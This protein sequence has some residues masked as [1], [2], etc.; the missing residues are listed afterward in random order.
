MKT[1]LIDEP[2]G[3]NVLT[4][5]IFIKEGGLGGQSLHLLTFINT[6]EKKK[7]HR[8]KKSNKKRKCSDRVNIHQ[9]KEEEGGWVA[10]SACTM[11]IQCSG[12]KKRS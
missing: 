5:S 4:A 9:F 2:R 3:E 10:P 7:M 6:V 12:L 1:Q 8:G 11:Q